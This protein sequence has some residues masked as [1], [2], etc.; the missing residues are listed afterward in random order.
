MT[1]KVAQD[2]DSQGRNRNDYPRCKIC[3]AS[4]LDK[5]VELQPSRSGLIFGPFP[6]MRL[7]MEYRCDDCEK[8]VC[9]SLREILKN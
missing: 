4:S 7:S 9:Q 1:H 8:K 6:G 2:L 5:N 3:K